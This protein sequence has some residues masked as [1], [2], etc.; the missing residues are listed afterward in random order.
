MAQIRITKI[1][2]SEEE[3]LSSSP[4]QVIIGFDSLKKINRPLR[5]EFCFITNPEDSSRDQKLD[6]IEIPKVGEG[7]F[8]FDWKVPSPNYQSLENA[9]DVFESMVV[10]LRVSI[11]K[12]EFFRCS[13]LI[14]H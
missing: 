8:V 4:F 7:A 1:E 11:D 10:L 2:F 3:S 9:L 6:T 5:F 13:Y 12:L 14:S